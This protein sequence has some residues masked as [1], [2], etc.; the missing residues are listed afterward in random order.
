M[1]GIIGFMRISICLLALLAAGVVLIVCPPRLFE[2]TTGMNIAPVSLWLF[3]LKMFAIPL[4]LILLAFTKSRL[5]QALDFIWGVWMTVTS[6]WVLG[7]SNVLMP[8]LTFYGQTLLAAIAL[9][10]IALVLF[11]AM[12]FTSPLPK[13]KPRKVKNANP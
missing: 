9:F 6:V 3:S 5:I 4:V 2:I 12:A 10:S 11:S 1:A 13:P 8:S 7:T